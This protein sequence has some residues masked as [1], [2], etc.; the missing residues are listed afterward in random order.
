MI[1]TANSA[2]QM[3]ALIQSI[4]MDT[5]ARDRN[6]EDGCAKKEGIRCAA[7][8]SK[9]LI[10]RE[11]PL[12]EKLPRMRV[13]LIASDSSSLV[14]AIPLGAR[15]AYLMQHIPSAESDAAG[16]KVLMTKQLQ[17][18]FGDDTVVEHSTQL[19]DQWPVTS[20]GTSR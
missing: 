3:Q 10:A 4:Q 12:M 20:L 2:E 13:N 7:L 5:N 19:L 14:K 11:D 6:L 8:G 1:A 16:K 9:T 18:E 17:L 15:L